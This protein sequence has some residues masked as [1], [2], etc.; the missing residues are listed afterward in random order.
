MSSSGTLAHRRS[1]S[2]DGEVTTQRPGDDREC[3]DLALGLDLVRVIPTMMPTRHLHSGRPR[4]D[5]C[6]AGGPL[7]E[8]WALL[9]RASLGQG[10]RGPMVLFVTV[11]MMMT[12]AMIA[13]LF[14]AIAVI[15]FAIA[16]RDSMHGER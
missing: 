7:C 16:L 2:V 14:L 3:L 10:R 1:T 9:R 11:L 6:E 4:G 12:S 13:V 15:F 5:G 8:I